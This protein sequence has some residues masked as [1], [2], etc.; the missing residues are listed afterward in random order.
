MKA[1][2][3]V[4]VDNVLVHQL[5]EC[6]DH[7]TKIGLGFASLLRDIGQDGAG[8]RTA[9]ASDALDDSLAKGTGAHPLICARS[10]SHES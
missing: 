9:P 7:M 10:T 4:H 5:I 3:G 6:V 2:V 8:V 1:L